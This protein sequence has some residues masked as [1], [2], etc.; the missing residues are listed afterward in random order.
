[1]TEGETERQRQTERRKLRIE[2]VEPRYKKG[3]S[4]AGRKRLVKRREIDGIR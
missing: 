2:V 4:V 3:K 1:M